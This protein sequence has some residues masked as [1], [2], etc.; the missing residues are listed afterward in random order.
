VL[1]GG[2]TRSMRVFTDLA[3]RAGL[4]VVAEAPSSFRGYAV[5]LQ[6]EEGSTTPG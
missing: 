1:L 6:R 4:A 5:Q 2:R 3:R